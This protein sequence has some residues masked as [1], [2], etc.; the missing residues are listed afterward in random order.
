[1]ALA[2]A[3]L[4][5]YSRLAA[6][7]DR[8]GL[9]EAV[10]LGLRTAF[11]V[12]LPCVAVIA[13][14]SG[15]MVRVLFERGAFTPESTERTARVFLYFSAGLWA[16][17]SVHVLARAFYALGDTVTPV[18]IAA[19]LVAANLAL[20]LTLVWTM[21]E[22]GL[23]LASSICGVANMTLLFVY[24]RRRIGPLGGS[25]VARSAAKCAAAAAVAG[26][27]GYAVACALGLSAGQGATMTQALALGAAIA[28]AGA[29]FVLAAWA[30]RVR[31]MG[32]FI[33]AV[34]M[35]KTPAG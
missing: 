19:V 27:A 30:L 32:E 26:V 10:N 22:A 24:L 2:T 12:A 3:V 4:P 16:F 29:A 1:M 15:P 6:Q 9:G 28:A 31:E 13:A 7:G 35:R 18:K 8:R 5:S 17:C 21:R 20:N 11:F 33:A 23:A 14:L 34:A 25:S